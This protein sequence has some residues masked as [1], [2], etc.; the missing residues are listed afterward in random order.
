M[1]YQPNLYAKVALDMDGVV[2]N[3]VYDYAKRIIQVSGKNLFEGE[4]PEPGWPTWTDWNMDLTVGYNKEDRN[5]AK[6]SIEKDLFFWLRLKT[7]ADTR[8]A[9]GKLIYLTD[10]LY[11]ITDRSGTSAKVQSEL[12]LQKL[13]VPNPTVLISAQKGDVCG[14]LGITHYIDDKPE[15]CLDAVQHGV[16]NVYMMIRPWNINTPSQSNRIKRVNTLTEFV[17]DIYRG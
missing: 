7:Y 5:R 9:M 1:N 4:E 10:N 14:A 11:F 13:L 2:A 15:N 3:Y 6:E 17:E 8:E 16:N 12:W